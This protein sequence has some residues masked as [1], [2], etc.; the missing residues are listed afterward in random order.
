MSPDFYCEQVLSGKTPVDVVLE[1]DRVL[2][3]HHTRPAWDMHIVIIPKDH[4]RVLTDVRDSTLLAEL[5]GVAQEIILRRGLNELNYKLI[6]NGGSY[7]SSQ[8]LHFHLVSGGP[9]DSTNPAQQG[10]LRV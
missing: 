7:Q 4:V 10:E 8:Q 3:F 9:R 6:T 5:L 1:T 2:A